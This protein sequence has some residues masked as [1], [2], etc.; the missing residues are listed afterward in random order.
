MNKTLSMIIEET[1]MKLVDVC[2]KSGLSLAVLDLIVRGLSDEIHM[3]ADRQLLE[4]KSNY[5]KAIK[6]KDGDIS[7][8]DDGDETKQ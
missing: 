8:K 3:L 5:I 6:D 1:R 7:S 4:E 2:S